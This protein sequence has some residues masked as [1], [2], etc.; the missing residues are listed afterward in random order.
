MKKLGLT[1]IAAL[2]LSSTQ[3]MAIPLSTDFTEIG[4]AGELI[5]Q[6]TNGPGTNITSISGTTGVD[7]GDYA[8][9]FSFNWSG[10]LF[11]AA[12]NGL[13]GS[14]R[15]FD[16]MLFLFNS[17]GSFITGNDDTSGPSDGLVGNSW[18]SYIS[19]DLTTGDYLLGISGWSYD[20]LNAAGA[21]F[22]YGATGILAS[23]DTGTGS[24]GNYTIGINSSAVP[25]PAPL[26]LLVLGLTALG[27]ARRKAAK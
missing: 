19:A 26:A 27:L 4:D 1:L 3:A 10:G 11:E 9:L 7:E 25:E 8:D 5:G 20:P 14:S 16:T 21:D 6:A 12:T 22:R 18:G 2:A 17:D 13:F 15:D 24:T 23:W